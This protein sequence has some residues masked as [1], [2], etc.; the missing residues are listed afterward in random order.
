MVVLV[1]ENNNIELAGSYY[2]ESSHLWIGRC[3]VDDVLLLP[4]LL[5]AVHRLNNGF[6]AER[7]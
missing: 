1:C 6:W 5:V 4:G 2:L 7:R 3:V